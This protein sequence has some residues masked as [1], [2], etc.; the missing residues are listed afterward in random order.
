MFKIFY[1]IKK[2]FSQT[3]GPNTPLCIPITNNDNH[4]ITIL[5]IYIV[6]HHFQDNYKNLKLIKSLT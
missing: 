5:L 1:K 3:R 4:A 2:R 6:F